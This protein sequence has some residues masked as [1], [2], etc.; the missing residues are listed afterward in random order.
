MR[1]TPGCWMKLWQLLR[2]FMCRPGPSPGWTASR[3]L[4]EMGLDSLSLTTVKHPVSLGLNDLSDLPAVS[5]EEGMSVSPEARLLF[6]GTAGE[7]IRR[8]PA[9]VN[10][11]VALAL[12][13]QGPG[14]TRMRLIADPLAG[15]TRHR[16]MARAG[17]CILDITTTP[18]PL[19]ENPR[20]SALALYSVSALL[21]QMAEPLRLAG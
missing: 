21:R 8:F 11:A 14:K 3:A 18:A 12:A 13:G 5:G 20:S 10:V 19:S 16:I 6:D 9:N 15:G 7:A 17:K 2:R 1:W 4:R